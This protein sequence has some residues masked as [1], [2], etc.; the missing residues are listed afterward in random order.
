MDYLGHRGVTDATIN[1]WMIGYNPS[2]QRIVLP[3]M[4]PDGSVLGVTERATQPYGPKYLHTK[5]L[6]TGRVLYGMQQPINGPV[7]L[8]EGPMDALLVSQSGYHA[9]AMQGGNL[10]MWQAAV[11]SGLTQNRGVVIYP[12]NDAMSKAR[13]WQNVLYK[14]RIPSIVP[15]AP[16]PVLS[17][18]KADPAWL[19]EADPIHLSVT[20]S[21]AL[22]RLSEKGA[23]HAKP[24]S[25]RVLEE[26]RKASRRQV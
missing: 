15:R 26:L 17:P 20:I 23:Y 7:I 1:E 4:F 13:R 10:S 21:T 19:A 16:Y 22:S 18:P 6:S 14:M 12:D 5:G 3:I 25:I 24:H 11:L 9:L 8:V 2:T